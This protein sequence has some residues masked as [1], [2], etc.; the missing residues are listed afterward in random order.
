MGEVKRA[1]TD[2]ASS[3]RELIEMIGH[4]GKYQEQKVE[5]QLGPS[6]TAP[7]IANQSLF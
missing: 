1:P 7:S 3:S 4:L 2:L 6:V 5:F